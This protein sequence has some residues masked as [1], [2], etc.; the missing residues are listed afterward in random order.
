M[1]LVIKIID[2][3]N[4]L[5]MKEQKRLYDIEY[6]RRT[7]AIKLKRDKQYYH[8]N[9]ELLYVKAR[10]RFNRNREKNLEWKREHGKQL[11][12]NNRMIVLQHYSR[13]VIQCACCGE[14]IYQFLQIDHIE[15]R[16]SMNHDVSYCG[17]KLYDWLINNKFPDG[18]R[19]LCANCNFGRRFTKDGI[20]PHQRI[21]TR[22]LF[23]ELGV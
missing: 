2:N 13:G 21:I 17:N 23:P 10:E 7:H 20:C 19:V 12:V 4:V 3:D 15:G 22:T 6:R 9:K 18:Y 5:R 11:R 1:I 14:L 8:D 16:K